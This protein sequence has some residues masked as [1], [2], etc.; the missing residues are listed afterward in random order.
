MTKKIIQER[1]AVVAMH[2]KDKQVFDLC[3]T[4]NQAI[5]EFSMHTWRT[6]KQSYRKGF[7]CVRV[8]I[9]IEVDT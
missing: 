1:W 3:R 2:R 6:W 4:R 9:V 5:R 8:K 7:R